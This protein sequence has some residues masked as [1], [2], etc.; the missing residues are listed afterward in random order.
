MRNFL[1]KNVYKMQLDFS[2]IYNFLCQQ[3]NIEGTLEHQKRFDEMKIVQTEQI[4]NTIANADQ[5]FYAMCDAFNFGIGKALLQSQKVQLKW[6]S[7]Q[8]DQE[9][10]K[11][12]NSDS[13]A[14]WEN[15]QP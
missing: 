11:K 3:N 4:L 9:F 7:Y 12:Q 14:L 10:L 13:L 8:Q 2:P 15:I 5:H 6:I 1:S